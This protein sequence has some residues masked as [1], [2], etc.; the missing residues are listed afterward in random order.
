MEPTPTMSATEFLKLDELKAQHTAAT[1]RATAAQ[2]S[3]LRALARVSNE[4]EERIMQLDS[5]NTELAAATQ[6]V[7]NAGGNVPP[8][9]DLPY[10]ATPT[11]PAMLALFHD[12][13]ALQTR[14]ISATAHQKATVANV[15]QERTHNARVAALR[16]AEHVEKH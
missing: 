7:T 9:F 11:S 8:H 14:V 16:A 6:A 4:V 1:D 13:R 10:L 12:V 5:A 15:V 2:Q 3:I